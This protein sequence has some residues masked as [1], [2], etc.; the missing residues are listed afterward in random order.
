MTSPI[1]RYISKHEVVQKYGAILPD[2]LT[3][4]E[5][6]DSDACKTYYAFASRKE[7]LKPKYVR[8]STRE[9]TDQPPKAS[10]GDGVDFQSKVPD[11]QHQKTFSQ[12]EDGAD[13]ETNVNDD[14]EETE[15]EKDGDDLTHPKLSTYKADDE[16]EEEKQMMM[17]YLQIIEYTHHQT[18]NSLMKMKI[19]KAMTRLRKAKRKKKKKRNYTMI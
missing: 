2:I 8:P 14:S 5:M 13:E 1:I 9:K 19:K 15:S 10:P 12:D 4:Q 17:K 6:K 16:E 18:I 7:I 11:E 3:N